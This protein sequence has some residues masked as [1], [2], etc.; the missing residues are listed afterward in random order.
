MSEKEKENKTERLKGY[1]ERERYW[2]DKSINQLSFSVQ[3]TS[4]LTL[5]IM[6]YILTNHNDYKFCWKLEECGVSAKNILYSFSLAF[7]IGS[8]F[9]GF[10][11]NLSRNQDMR[12]TRHICQTR[13]N[14]YNSY[15]IILDPDILDPDEMKK[16]EPEISFI[17]LLITDFEHFKK[18]QFCNEEFPYQFEALRKKSHKLG[19]YTWEFHCLQ[20][21]TLFIALIFYAISVIC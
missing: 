11:S 13:S 4:A 6:G 15:S 14:S 2:T 1:K 17:S 3:F 10:L 12:M 19:G 20:I 8:V 9:I 5:T 21:W 16:Y 7:I 18:S